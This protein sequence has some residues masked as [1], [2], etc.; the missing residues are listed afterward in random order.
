MKLIRIKQISKPVRVILLLALV[1][2]ALIGA[3]IWAGR[4][5]HTSSKQGRPTLES[6]DVTPLPGHEDK[7]AQ[8]DQENHTHN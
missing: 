1:L 2:V 6:L 5:H 8:F 4:P 3:Y 7:N